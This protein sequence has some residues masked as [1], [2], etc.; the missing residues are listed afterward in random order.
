MNN[1]WDSNILQD[2][3][4]CASCYTKNQEILNNLIIEFA[5]P[6]DYDKFIVKYIETDDEKITR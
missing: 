5:Q 6:E 1:Y 3:Y 2:I 4:Y